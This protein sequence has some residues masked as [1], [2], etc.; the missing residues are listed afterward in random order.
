MHLPNKYWYIF[1]YIDISKVKSA[2]WA[3][4]FSGFFADSRPPPQLF[5]V[6][7]Q[8]IGPGATIAKL[9]FRSDFN[10]AGVSQF[11]DVVR[12]SGLRHR[13]TFDDTSARQFIGR[14]GHF[15]EDLEATGIG[16]GFGNALKLSCIHES[17]SNIKRTMARSQRTD[18][19]A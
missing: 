5:D 13:K 4:R 2:L 11:F 14:G 9:T 10:Q 8:N 6:L 3:L 18:D 19:Y 16:E 12:D 1:I 15:L 7:L 17:Y